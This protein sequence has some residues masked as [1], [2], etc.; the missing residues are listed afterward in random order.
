LVFLSKQGYAIFTS[1]P[2]PQL[3]ILPRNALANLIPGGRGGTLARTTLI[4]GAV[5]NTATR[6]ATTAVKGGGMSARL[7]SQAQIKKAAEKNGWNKSKTVHKNSNKY[8]GETH[9]YRIKK[10]GKTHK[11]GESAR[12]TRKKDGSSIR[13]EEQVRELNRKQGP[14]FESEIR[15]T[16][17]NKNDAKKYETKVIQRFKRRYGEDSLPGNRSNH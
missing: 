15:K 16:F 3:L 10:N 12:G 9:V 4:R 1:F 6:T 5:R 7:P 8:E 11:I 14:G 13:A 2:F 17:K